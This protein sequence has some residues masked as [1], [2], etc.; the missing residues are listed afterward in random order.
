MGY[1]KRG[2]WFQVV[3]AC[4]LVPVNY[5]WRPQFDVNWA[6][7]PF[8]REQHLV[9]GWIYVMAY[10]VV[11][12]CFVYWPTHLALERWMRRRNTAVIN[13]HP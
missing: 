9:P 6:R 10:L 5:W 11:V 8:F 13:V 3:T 2:L 7:G 12:S 1:D 4:V